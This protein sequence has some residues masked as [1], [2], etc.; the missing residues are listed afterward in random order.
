MLT[1]DGCTTRR[2]RLW[3][4]LP[5]QIEW[6]LVADPRHVHYL[7]GF[8]I[9]PLSFSAGE[10]SRLLLDRRHGATLIA[11]NFARRSAVATPHVDREETVTWYD[12]HRSVENRD[13]ALLEGLK[14]TLSELTGRPGLIDADWCSPAER[15][16]LRDAGL[17][18][19]LHCPD[20]LTLGDLLRILRRQ[21]LP[22]ELRLLQTCMDAGAAGQRAG[23]QAVRAGVSEFDVYREIHRSVLEAAATPCLLYGDFRAVSPEVPKAG[24]LPTG[25]VL[26][27]GELMI[28]DFSVVIAGYRSD[29][30]NT[31]AV[32]TPTAEQTRL[33][34]TCCRALAA[35]ESKLLP[36][37]PASD[38]FHAVSSVLEEAGY[39]PLRH[40]AGHGIGLAHPEPPIFVENSRDVLQVG[41]VVTLEPGAYVE[42]I[43][44]VRV[45]HNYLVTDSGPQRLS[46]HQLRLS[47]S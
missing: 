47:T 6:V 5:E 37:T 9:N 17:D 4:R 29:F 12:H 34:E 10:R 26:A 19:H 32:G 18:V 7:S 15:A 22:D 46:E 41:D 13:R 28:L 36:G 21:K 42:G 44:G 11:D 25:H 2:D 45:E 31:V 14:R 33:F 3:E 43:G 20:A 8:W 23:L 40:H 38:V 30:T 24:G 27:D 39:G 35:G 16:L 1:A